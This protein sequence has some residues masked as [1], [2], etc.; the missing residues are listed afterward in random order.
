MAMPISILIRLKGDQYFSTVSHE[1]STK[2][3]VTNMPDY[4]LKNIIN[5]N[6][7]CNSY[8]MIYNAS[9]QINYQ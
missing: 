6:L 1:M 4:N 2:E 5:G 8:N 9:K 7:A 3:T